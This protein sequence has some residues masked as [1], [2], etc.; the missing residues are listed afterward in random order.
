MRGDQGGPVLRPRRRRVCQRGGHCSPA[1]IS[2]QPLN[3]ARHDPGSLSLCRA[4]RYWPSR[5]GCGHDSG[6]DPS[7]RDNDRLAA[8]RSASWRSASMRAWLWQWSG[9]ARP[10]V[11]VPPPDV[12]TTEVEDL[13][14]PPTTGPP[15][16]LVPGVPVQSRPGRPDD[17]APRIKLCRKNGCSMRRGSGGPE[18]VERVFSHP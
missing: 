16:V 14:H 2:L 7:G 11:R 17:L 18:K 9:S 5:A 10:V 6:P 8:D 12:L 15:H 1:A 3:P 13:M 4:G